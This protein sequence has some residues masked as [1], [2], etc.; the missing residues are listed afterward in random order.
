MSRAVERLGDLYRREGNDKRFRIFEEFTSAS[1][2]AAS[3]GEIASRHGVTSVDVNNWLTDA[4][5]RLRMIVRDIVAETVLDEEG[6]RLELRELFS[7][8]APRRED[9]A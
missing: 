1:D 6:L 5:R 9:R 7:E 4:R 3:H 8:A 2:G